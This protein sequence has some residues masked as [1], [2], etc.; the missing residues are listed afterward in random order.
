MNINKV[1]CEIV[2]PSPELFLGARRYVS[3]QGGPPGSVES[4][5]VRGLAQEWEP[6]VPIKHLHSR[7]R[8]PLCLCVH[9]QVL[10]KEVLVDGQDLPDV[11]PWCPAGSMR[12]VSA[13]GAPTFGPL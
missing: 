1:I 5:F 2:I 6:G 11:G 3:L 10:N 8:W 4:G 9:G 7:V 13:P 12:G